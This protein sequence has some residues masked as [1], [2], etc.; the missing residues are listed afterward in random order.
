V[1]VNAQLIDAETGAHLWADRF[2]EDITDLFKL[3]DTIVAHLASSLNVALTK[4]EAEK[5]A[6]SSNPTPSIWL[7]AV[8]TWKTTA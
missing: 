7:C 5:G 8:G 6:R 4:A 1:R 3:Q 2:D